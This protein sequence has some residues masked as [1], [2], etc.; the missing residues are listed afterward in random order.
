M[1]P[2]TFY[3]LLFTFYLLPAKRGSVF[4]AEPRLITFLSCSAHRFDFASY[5]ENNY[6]ENNGNQNAC[7]EGIA[8]G[9]NKNNSHQGNDGRIEI[10]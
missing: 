1:I 3:L 7:D 8:N 9:A 5:H 4:Q 2:S 10:S 6:S